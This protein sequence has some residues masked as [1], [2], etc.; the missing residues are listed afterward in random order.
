MIDEKK[1]SNLKLELLPYLPTDRAKLWMDDVFDLARLGLWAMDYAIPTLESI[2]E[3]V[4]SSKQ[5]F[6]LLQSEGAL[7]VLPKRKEE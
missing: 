5:H 7:K 3:K 6:L 4:V 2:K 1:L